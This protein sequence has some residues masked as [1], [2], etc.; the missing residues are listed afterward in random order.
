M[1]RAEF[2]EMVEDQLGDFRTDQV[3]KYFHP[4]IIAYT[5]D[6]DYRS[7]LGQA[8]R[9]QPSVIEGCADRV[10]NVPV[11]AD[12]N[13]GKLFSVIPK[14][15]IPLYKVKGGV[16]GVW[17]H[18]DSSVKFEPYSVGVE[19]R[20]WDRLSISKIANIV[21][22]SFDRGVP[23]T[24]ISAS[25]TANTVFTDYQS[26]VWYDA[27]SSQL[28]NSDT[29]DMDILTAFYDH[30][31]DQEVYVPFGNEKFIIESTMRTL[32]AKLGLSTEAFEQKEDS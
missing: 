17:K 31:D 3:R 9:K 14:A 25:S 28:T 20:D 5:L 7:Y 6:K 16:F 1:T 10:Y 13:T 32:Y 15:V 2:I 8:Y 26:L 21:R 27:T 4:E 29:V 22:W 30:G 12:N 11:Y 24:D 18:G 23:D 19:K